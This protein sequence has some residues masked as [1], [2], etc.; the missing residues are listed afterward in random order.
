M[1]LLL[2]L[3]IFFNCDT[4]N[5]TNYYFS[6]SGNDLNNGTSPSSPWQSISKFNAVFAS[7]SPGDSFLF[8]RGDT[9]YGK[10]VISRSGSSGL[11]ITIGAYGTGANPVITGF[12]TVRA[13]TNLGSNIWE[14]TSAVSGLSTCNMVVIN[15]VNTPMGRY[16]NTGYLT[17]EGFTKT[18]ITSSSLN[19]SATDWT[20]AVAVI[21]KN[22]WI[23][24][25]DTIKKQSGITL[26]HTAHSIYNGIKNYGFFI[27]ND[28]KTLDQQNEWYF[29]PSAKKLKIYS[30][31]YPTKVQV[32]LID[33]L[34]SI[35]GA[36]NIT[37]AN[38]SFRGSNQITFAINYSNHINIS[39]CSINYSGGNAIITRGGG[40]DYFK[41]IN[42]IIN[43]TNNNGIDL[44]GAS[45]NCRL[46]S[47]TI[48]NTGMFAGMG[49]NSDKTFIAVQ[50]NSDNGI[51]ENCFIDNTGYNGI[52]FYGNNTIAR[53]NFISNFCMVKLDGGGIY[54]FVGKE[55]ASKGQK[56][57]NNIVING[58]GN[59]EGTSE[60]IPLVHGIYIDEGSSNI[61]ITGNTIANNSYS[62]L[63]CHNSYSND[64]YNNTLYNNGYCQFLMA[65]YNIKNAERNLRFK[66]NIL[67]SKKD[68][69]KISSFQSRANDI[70]NFG[71][72]QDIDYN[73]YLFTADNNSVFETAI[74][75]YKKTSQ[76]TLPDWQSYSGYD[77][78]S[79]RLILTISNMNSLKL[80]Y[81]QTRSDKIIKLNS[82]YID[83]RNNL[84][85]RKI[86]IHPFSSVVLIKKE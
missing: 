73:Y 39:N 23:I 11:P 70:N 48:K 76:L 15:G 20:G 57:Q 84:Y 3:L 86:I 27:Q 40:C 30:R 42:S 81:N 55:R 49:G 38:I 63:Y 17:Y 51:I 2:P 62:G 46:T 53:N 54:T 19:L 12:T 74:N 7:K 36:D 5:A 1:K 22:N 79:V 29:N 67:V 21:K 37:F 25:R 4:A 80:E 9:F 83:V 50:N 14:S 6:V 52:E 82:P 32:P 68:G 33:T 10:L 71:L 69:Q 60:K 58:V 24:D 43:H 66:Y 44:G 56:L 41:L 34:V 85:T 8:N 77:G 75:N 59:I 16:P 64:I 72:P 13:W 18:S 65:G 28:P 45:P 47:D 26:I 78:H 35:N 31:N 61:E